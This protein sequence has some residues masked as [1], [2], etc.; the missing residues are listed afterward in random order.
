MYHVWE[1]WKY[2]Q[3]FELK[4]LNERYN[5]GGIDTDVRVWAG[6]IWFGTG[7]AAASC[8]HDNETSVP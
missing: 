1:K 7:M 2:I 3:K 6:F 8:E 5:M 4:S